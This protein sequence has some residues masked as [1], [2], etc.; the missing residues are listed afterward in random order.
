MD[1]MEKCGG[2]LE[3]DR[4]SRSVL[5]QTNKKDLE[6]ELR[7]G[8]VKARRRAPQVAVNILVEL[9]KQVM[10]EDL[11]DYWRAHAFF[12]LCKF[13]MCMRFDD[14]LGL[15]P[16]CFSLCWTGIEAEF[17]RTKVSG[18]GK[19]V[20]VVYGYVSLEAY[21]FEGLDQGRL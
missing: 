3:V 9:E 18:S 8:K 14:G 7:T 10:D 17:L 20:E 1:F 15:P 13:W 6:V 12:K 16:R 21:V 11:V 19:R 5:V 2:V 4:M